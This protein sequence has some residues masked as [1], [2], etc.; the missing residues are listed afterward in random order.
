MLR[1]DD[2]QDMKKLGFLL[3]ED[4]MDENPVK[5]TVK[6]E[7]V[8]INLSEESE[9]SEDV[10]NPDDT[11]TFPPSANVVTETLVPLPV[12][13]EPRSRASQV[14]AVAVLGVV[15]AA[16]SSTSTA[17]VRVD[18]LINCPLCKDKEGKNLASS[19]DLKYHISVC[20][21]R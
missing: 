6:K 16:S 12:R 2:N 20:A 15:K 5:L 9:N 7:N 8:D 18:K 1:S 3:Y 4:E 17:A 11:S 14:L 21:Y 10:D 19:T 13:R